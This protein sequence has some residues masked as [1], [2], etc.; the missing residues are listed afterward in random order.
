M[1]PRSEECQSR[2]AFPESIDLNAVAASL[3]LEPP[4]NLFSQGETFLSL[5]ISA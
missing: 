3:S 5:E 4:D 1:I 2:V